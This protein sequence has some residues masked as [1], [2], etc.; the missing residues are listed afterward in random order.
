MKEGEQGGPAGP[1]GDRP[2]PRS[3]EEDHARAVAGAGGQE[4]DGSDRGEGEVALATGRGAE[5]HGGRSV[6]QDPRL[7]LPVGDRVPDVD[8]PAAGRQRPVDVANLVAPL[9][10]T[11]VT[12]L[13][14][15]AGQEALVVALEQPV[16]L[17]VHSQLE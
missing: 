16:Q 8:G 9:V 4:P 10:Q 5:L 13:G 12:G 6:D 7:Q 2:G 15:G 1:S 3:V 14:A 17:A 11:G